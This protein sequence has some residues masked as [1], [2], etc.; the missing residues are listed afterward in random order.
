MTYSPG[1]PGYPSAQQ[2]TTQFAAP[3]QSLAKTD[4][5]TSKIPMYLMAAVAAL[6]LAAYLVSFGPVWE[7]SDLGT[8]AGASIAGGSF[9][10]IAV[11]LAALLAGVGLIPKQK[12]YI[13]VVAVIAVVGFLLAVAEIINKPDFV[14]VGWAMIVIVVLAGLQAV[15]AV[16]ALLLDAGVITPPAPKQK[17]DQQYGQYGGPGQYYGGQP[18]GQPGQHA[19]GQQQ[20]PQQH[21]APQRPGYPPQQ[22]G[23]YPSGPGTGG[24]AAPGH[25]SGPPTPPTGYPSFSQ[26][27]SQGGAPGQGQGQPPQQSQPTQSSQQSPSS[28]PSGPTPSGP[29]PS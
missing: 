4:D 24:F 28:T 15:A 7:S 3:A 14:S 9:E 12:S 8:V 16:T 2:P 1:N 26:P 27:Q 29:A 25:Q 11:V 17:H 18:A 22:Y 21:Q 23:G 13:P 5:G 20:N 6:G 10:I 19:P